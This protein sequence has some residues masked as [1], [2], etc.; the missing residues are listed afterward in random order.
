MPFQPLGLFMDTF[1]AA[2][3]KDEDFWQTC[4]YPV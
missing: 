3:C 4:H 1:A 2:G